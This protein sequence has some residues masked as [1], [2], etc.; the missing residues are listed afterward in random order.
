MNSRGTFAVVV[1]ALSLGLSACA[2]VQ[3]GSSPS[4]PLEYDVAPVKVQAGETRYV[5][6]V[7]FGFFFGLSG[8]ELGQGLT[9]SDAAVGR[10]DRSARGDFF[11]HNIAAPEGWKVSLASA[12]NWRRV[13][14]VDPDSVSYHS[15]VELVFEVQVP[16]GAPTGPQA[17]RAVVVRGSASRNI[18]FEVIP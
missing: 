4:N 14:A 3:L 17:I 7:I 15:G 16:K 18:A 10:I 6:V 13:V 5:S 12:N 11:T 9:F 8:A 1:L 2:P